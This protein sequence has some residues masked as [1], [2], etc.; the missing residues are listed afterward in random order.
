MVMTR[1]DLLV[2]DWS[3]PHYLPT[4][5]HVLCCITLKA[6]PGCRKWA[7][8]KYIYL[9][10]WNDFSTFCSYPEFCL[11]VHWLRYTRSSLSRNASIQAW[12]TYSWRPSYLCWTFPSFHVLGRG[13]NQGIESSRRLHA[14]LPGTQHGVSGFES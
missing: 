3:Y 14:A 8:T 6:R 9:L 13:G 1:K 12:L 11:P 4:H 5:L 10:S 7:F 2:G